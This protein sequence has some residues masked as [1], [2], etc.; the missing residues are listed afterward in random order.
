MKKILS[1]VGLTLLT[2]GAF[3]ADKGGLF[4]EP[5]ITYEQ[6]DGKINYPDPINS[7]DTDVNGFGVGT[8][9]GFHLYESFFLGVDGRYSM[10][11]FKDSSLDQNTDAK[12]WNY[13]PVAGVQMPT[14]LGLRVWGGYIIDGELDPD[15]DKNVNQKFTQANGYRL[16]AGIKIGFASLNLEYQQL[17]YDR[18]K[19]SEVGVFNTNQTFKNVELDNDTWIVSVSFPISL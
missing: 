4:I 7:S 19:V 6:G 14:L 9:L 11:T 17:T 1:I 5:M 15:K 13:G 3:A 10:P 18:T 12:A 16:G 2:S 8:R